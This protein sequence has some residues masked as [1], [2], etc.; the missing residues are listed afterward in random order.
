MEWNMGNDNKIKISKK[1]VRLFLQSDMLPP[2]NDTPEYYDLEAEYAK[3]RK[4]KSHFTI[5]AL[6]LFSLGIALLVYGVTSYISF[7]NTSLTVG[8]DVFEDLNLKNLLDVVSRTESSMESAI[9]QKVQLETDR[10][11]E[12][13]QATIKRDSEL[14]R[15]ETSKISN[16]SKISFS[17]S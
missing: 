10:D 7:R 5:W 6:V 12:L 8:V 11:A 2:E 15:L 13:S 3:T 16:L 1:E 4:E 14:L 17:V 9:N